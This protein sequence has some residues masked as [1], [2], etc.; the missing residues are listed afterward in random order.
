MRVLHVTECFEGGVSR[1][2]HSIVENSSD[3]EHL[4]LHKGLDLPSS[5]FTVARR[6][7]FSAIR[8]DQWR[9]AI[10][11]MVA[12][13]RPDVI[14]AHS[15]WSGLHAR[16]TRQAVPVIYQPHC[17]AFDMRTP[18]APAYW[19]A[20]RVVARNTATFLTL[21]E[22]E[23]AQARRLG[24]SA[25]VVTLPNVSTL[26][27]LN[28]DPVQQPDSVP[29]AELQPDAPPHAHP[30]AVSGS[31]PTIAMVGRLCPQKDPH[32][33][34]EIRRRAPQDWRFLWIGDGDSSMRSELVSAGVDVTGWLG[35]DELAQTL[36]ACDAYAH[37][38]AWEG[39]PL[40]VLDAD[41]CGV[42][43]VARRIPAFAATE[44]PV[45]DSPSEAVE[46][47]RSALSAQRPR[48]GSQFPTMTRR[49]Q[50]R[51]LDDVYARA[52]EQGAARVDP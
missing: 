25:A 48:P 38:A 51:V 49:E 43:I 1:A 13:H 42:P 12:Q 16:L 31:T 2:I 27:V 19:L 14:H 50:R 3:H 26:P 45:F 4:L 8:W 29:Q 18:L 21:S 24:K 10:A 33:F 40:S 23:S 30:A 39:F 35:P 5:A 28:E 37:T 22:H 44:V 46:L 52:A 47:L 34:A 6:V 15:S 41:A 20:E 32:L 11:E 7:D 36:R 9:R 17:F